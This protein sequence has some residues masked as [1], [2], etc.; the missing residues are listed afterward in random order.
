LFG[1]EISVL[2]IPQGKVMEFSFY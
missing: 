1:N 2:A